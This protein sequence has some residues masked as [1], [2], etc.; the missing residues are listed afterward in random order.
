MFDELKA[1][2]DRFLAERTASADPRA[3]ALLLKEA[4]LEAKVGVRVIRESLAK[5]E[6]ELAAERRQLAAAARRGALA[7]GIDDVETVAVAAKFAAKHRER[8]QVLERKVAVQ[9]DELALAE[10]EVEEMMA[11]LKA[12]RHGDGPRINVDSAWSAVG[13]AG[14]THPGVDEVEDLKQ[15]LD[16]AGMDAAVEAQLAHLK[17]KLGKENA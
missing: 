9:R 5:A 6:R 14:G 1:K 16:R 7:A 11:Q 2:L 10:K 4:L 15:D 3:R 8:V 17:R 12:S 13:S